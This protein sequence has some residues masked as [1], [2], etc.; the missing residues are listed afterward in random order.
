MPFSLARRTF[1]KKRGKGK[2]RNMT[3]SLT[4]A[5]NSRCLT[6][7]IWQKRPKE[8][9]LDAIESMLSESSLNGI[10]TVCL[11]GGEPFLRTDLIRIFNHV[12]KRFPEA[13]ILLSTN[14][15]LRR[16][17]LDFLNAACQKR[18][19]L[20]VSI[21]GVRKHDHVRG[22]DGALARTKRTIIDALDQHPDLRVETKFTITPWNHDE[23]LDA[24]RL[25]RDLGTVFKIKMIQNLRYY[26]NPI[27]HEQNQTR[28]SFTD[29]QRQSIIRDLR[30][31]R[32]N[33]MREKRLADAFFTRLMIQ[34]LKGDQF[35]LNHCNCIFSSLF[36]MPDG[37]AYLCRNMAPIGNIR[38]T[39]LPQIWN[40]SKANRI[41][42]MFRSGRCPECISFYGF[43]N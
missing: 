19:G 21:D 16:N 35:R 12:R 8:L 18:L 38:T 3:L 43:S 41:R 24:Y 32:G 23:I 22:V 9:P 11:T 31:L 29:H 17:I 2:L 20:H 39:S 36:V 30:A 40:S 25:S 7:D 4:D 13:E 34:Y 6:C 10:R 1:N 26:T 42:N 33:F 37:S 15:L 28:F 27:R 5:C 14:G